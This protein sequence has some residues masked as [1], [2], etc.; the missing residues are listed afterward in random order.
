MSVLSFRIAS[1]TDLDEVL[2][3]DDDVGGLLRAIRDLDADDQLLA[4]L[5]AEFRD[6]RY[7]LPEELRTGEDAIDLESPQTLRQALEEVKHLLLGRLLSRG[8]TP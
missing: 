8:D 3:S 2:G 1:E 7:K 6:L 5:A 4:D